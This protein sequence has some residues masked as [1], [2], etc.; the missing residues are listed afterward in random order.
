MSELIKNIIIA[1]LGGSFAL[2]LQLFANRKKRLGNRRSVLYILLEV[3]WNITRLE[4]FKESDNFLDKFSSKLDINPIE[5]NK[6][7]PFLNEILFKVMFEGVIS[8]LKELSDSYSSL[9]LSLASEEPILA[10][11]ISHL[12]K[13]LEK[14]K[15][16]FDGLSNDMKAQFSKSEH[17][18]IDNFIKNIFHN[19]IIFGERENVQISILKVGR[20]ISF[21]QY[22]KVKNLI[23]EI[24]TNQ[25]DEAEIEKFVSIIMQEIEKKLNTL[26]D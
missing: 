1:F 9:I 20:S 15:I 22:F 25:V 12:A 17:E 7:K 5:I 23:K 21:I 16:Y 6:V 3:Y 11:K 10:Y 2:V 4:R 19:N 24:N 14:S 8:E 26:N 18:Q 13:S